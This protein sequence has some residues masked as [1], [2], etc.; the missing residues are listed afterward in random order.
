MIWRALQLAVESISIE[1]CLYT[2]PWLNRDELLAGRGTEEPAEPL[3]HTADNAVHCV[4]AA[5]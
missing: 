4:S 3:R 2:C 1:G 5:S